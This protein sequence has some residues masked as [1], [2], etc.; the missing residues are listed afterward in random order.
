MSRFCIL[1][2]LAQK[3]INRVD[4]VVWE[5]LKHTCIVKQ[6]KLKEQNEEKNSNKEVFYT[7]VESLS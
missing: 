5:T 3:E 7:L 6:C 2:K 1:K 4:K